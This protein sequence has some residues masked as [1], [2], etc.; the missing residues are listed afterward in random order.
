MHLAKEIETVRRIASEVD[1]YVYF[2][3]QNVGFC[4]LIR[5]KC[6]KKHL[7]MKL[8]IYFFPGKDTPENIEDFFV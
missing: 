3:C 8:K 7:V 5:C 2:K 1:V 4:I 6:V